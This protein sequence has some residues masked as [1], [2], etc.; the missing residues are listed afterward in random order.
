MVYQS[1][2]G[3]AVAV[4]HK[5]QGVDERSVERAARFSRCRNTSLWPPA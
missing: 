1:I 2:S 3:K 5:A 4:I